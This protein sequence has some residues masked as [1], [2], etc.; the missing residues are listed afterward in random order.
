MIKPVSPD[1]GEMKRE[2]ESIVYMYILYIMYLHIMCAKWAV[3]FTGAKA[4]LKHSEF[5]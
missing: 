2:R 1:L 4:K 3:A 5:S